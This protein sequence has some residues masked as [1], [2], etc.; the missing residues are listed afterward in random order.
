MRYSMHVCCRSDPF[1]KLFRYY[2]QTG[3]F[4]NLAFVPQLPSIPDPAILLAILLV[5]PKQLA[6]SGSPVL[7]IDLST[8]TL[9]DLKAFES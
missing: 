4:V 6:G 3:M 5:R 1:C 2:L 9:Q 7:E 8:I